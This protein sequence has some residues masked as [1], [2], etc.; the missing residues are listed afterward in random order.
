MCSIVLTANVPLAL[1]LLRNFKTGVKKYTEYL[2]EKIYH[3]IFQIKIKPSN[4]VK[5]VLSVTIHL[6]I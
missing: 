2:K 4:S 5:P 1:R 6:F 3:Y